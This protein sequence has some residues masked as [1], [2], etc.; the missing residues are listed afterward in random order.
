MKTLIW[1]FLVVMVSCNDTDSCDK[2]TDRKCDG[3][4]LL[5][6][7]ADLE[8]EIENDCANLTT[9]DGTIVHGACCEENGA[10]K[11]RKECEL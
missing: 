11:C 4:E 2:W 3:D 10:V 1:L 5:Y 6:C 7:N 9:L 8:W